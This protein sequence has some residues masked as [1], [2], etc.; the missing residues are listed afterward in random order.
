M[1]YTEARKDVLRQLALASIRTNGAAKR[2]PPALLEAARAQN[3]TNTEWLRE[4]LSVR[5]EMAHGSELVGDDSRKQTS[6]E[7]WDHLRT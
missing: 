5:I 4:R 2:E 6:R 3:I 1:R 7:H